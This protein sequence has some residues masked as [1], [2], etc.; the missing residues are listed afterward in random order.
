M[1]AEQAD[2]LREAAALPALRKMLQ[3]FSGKP[4][5]YGDLVRA[6]VSLLQSPVRAPAEEVSHV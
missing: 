4:D 3:P 2:E 5:A 1:P 6:I